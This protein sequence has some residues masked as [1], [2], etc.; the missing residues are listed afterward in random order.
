MPRKFTLTES[1]YVRFDYLTLNAAWLAEGIEQIEEQYGENIEISVDYCF[2]V[3]EDAL[4][5]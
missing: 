4:F 5:W 1:S 3:S 2:M